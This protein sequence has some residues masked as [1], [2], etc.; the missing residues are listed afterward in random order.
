MNSSGGERSIETLSPV[1]R[2]HPEYADRKIIERTCEAERQ[3]IFRL[4]RMAYRDEVQ[5]NRDSA[6]ASQSVETSGSQ[7]LC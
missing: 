6:L 1:A 7:M 3:I 5:I 2:K 4:P